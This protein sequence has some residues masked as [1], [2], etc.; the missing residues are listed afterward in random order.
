MPF[1]D[2]MRH[3]ANLTLRLH[4]IKRMFE[5]KI[6]VDAIRHVL[7]TG[8][9]MEDYPTDTPYP[10]CLVLGWYRMRPLHIVVAYNT[11]ND[12]TI[13]IT[14]YEPDAVQWDSNFKRRL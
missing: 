13:V 3:P 9:M 2:A 10:S 7:K 4:A 1:I 12:E 11:Q 14:A 8:E 5:R 6:D